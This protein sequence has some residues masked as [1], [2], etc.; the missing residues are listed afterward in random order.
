MDLLNVKVKQLQKEIAVLSKGV[1]NKSTLTIVRNEK[2]QDNSS[3]EDDS[4]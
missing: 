4:N 1:K 3:N 2:E